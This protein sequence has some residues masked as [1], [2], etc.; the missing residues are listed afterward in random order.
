M[1]KGPESQNLS[2]DLD[3]LEFRGKMLASRERIVAD[4]DLLDR[5]GVKAIVPNVVEFFPAALARLEAAHAREQTARQEIE[6]LVKA[7]FEAQ[8]QTNAL[9]LNLLES[10]NNSDLA[11]RL[12]EAAKGAFGL[13]AGVLACETEVGERRTPSGWEALPVGG[14]DALLGEG[15]ETRL[16]ACYP[17]RDV[18]PN[19][20]LPVRSCA[21]I[22]ISLWTEERPGLLA[23]ASADPEGFTP[24]MGVE[25]IRFLARVSERI[26]ARWPCL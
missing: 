5:L 21:L 18:F 17:A 11:R 9:V 23:F 4:D 7:N 8:A 15:R 14:V 20:D 6:S 25:L 26:A 16:G 24:S 12:D 2:T 3:W 22:R 10:R 19:T 1:D 13:Q